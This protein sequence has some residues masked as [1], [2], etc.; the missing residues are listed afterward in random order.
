M[1]YIGDYFRSKEL[2]KREM[3]KQDRIYKVLSGKCLYGKLDE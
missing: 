2:D 3:S 1:S